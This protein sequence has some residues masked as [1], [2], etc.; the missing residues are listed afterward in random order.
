V[1]VAG[2]VVEST[3]KSGK[4]RTIAL[5]AGTVS[6]LRAH[7]RAQLEERLAWGEAWTESGYL[8]VQ[9]DGNPLRPDSVTRAF[10]VHAAA[11]GLPKRRLHDLRHSHATLGLGAGIATKVMSERLGH[12]RT[13]ITEDLYSHVTKTMQE[14]AAAKLGALV[15]GS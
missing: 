9:Q 3:P 4:T 1:P 13:A 11:A 14:D 10:E 15:L 2:R 12:A 5:D 6:A 8:F 7:R